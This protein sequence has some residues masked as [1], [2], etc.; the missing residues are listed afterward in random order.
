MDREKLVDIL[1]IYVGHINHH[2][3]MI[4]GVKILT[5][6][7]IALNVDGIIQNLQNEVNKIFKED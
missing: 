1:R 7:E 5:D 2:I 6:F 3:N 4:E